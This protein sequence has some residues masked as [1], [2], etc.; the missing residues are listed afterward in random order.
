MTVATC[1][2]CG[3]LVDLSP[4]DDNAKPHVRLA[5]L[6]EKGQPVRK[7]DGRVAFEILHAECTTSDA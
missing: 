5:V 3:R 2:A 4:P 1:G 7:S 6:D